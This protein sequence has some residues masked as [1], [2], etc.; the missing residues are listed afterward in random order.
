MTRN[1]GD[2]ARLIPLSTEI[3]TNLLVCVEGRGRILW[4]GL[5]QDILNGYLCMPV[6]RTGVELVPMECV[7]LMFIFGC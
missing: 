1:R 6:W 4:S 2:Q 5:T 3:S 7:S